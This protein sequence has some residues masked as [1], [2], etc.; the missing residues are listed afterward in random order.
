MLMAQK[1]LL[2]LTTLIRGAGTMRKRSVCLSTLVLS[3]ASTIIASSP[4][5]AIPITYTEQ[6]TATGSLGGVAFTD[7]SIVLTMNNDTTHVTGGPTV[8]VNLGT[9]MLEVG[10]GPLAT[11]TDPTQIAANHSA[12][13]AGFGDNT[14]GLAILFTGNPLISTYDLTTSIGPL[15]GTALFNAGASF[16]TTDG[17]F[18]LNSVTGSATFTAT[19]AAPEPASLTLLGAALVGLGLIRRRRRT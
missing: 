3:V 13:D 9:V 7:A 6:V 17:S 15:L 14:V 5:G 18:V 12:L 10:G 1:L 19:T 8:F 11:F 16:P 4:A 2:T